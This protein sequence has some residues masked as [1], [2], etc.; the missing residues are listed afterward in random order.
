MAVPGMGYL[1]ELMWH[2]LT[3]EIAPVLAFA[4]DR[5]ALVLLVVL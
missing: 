2:P 3:C 5:A 4:F 1:F